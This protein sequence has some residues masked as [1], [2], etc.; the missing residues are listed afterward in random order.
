MIPFHNNVDNNRWA[1]LQTDRGSNYSIPHQLFTGIIQPVCDV[2]VT[3]IS[4]S[5]YRQIVVSNADN[6]SLHWWKQDCDN[7]GDI[8]MQ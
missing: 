2:I 3:S 6:Q 1:G 7:P 8:Y 4:L 5:F